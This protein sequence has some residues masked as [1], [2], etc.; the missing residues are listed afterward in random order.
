VFHAC[1][2]RYLGGRGRRIK[3]K[4]SL[5]KSRRPCFKN[6]LITKDPGMA[7]VVKHLPCKCEALGTIL[8]TAKKKFS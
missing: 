1:N 3:Y 5:G 2:L 8:S 4:A 7:Q 6:K